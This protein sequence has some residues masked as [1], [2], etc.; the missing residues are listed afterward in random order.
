MRRGC[1]AEIRAPLPPTAFCENTPAHVSFLS[2]LLLPSTSRFPLPSSPQHAP[3]LRQVGFGPCAASPPLPSPAQHL[4]AEP[5]RHPS[6]PSPRATHLRR[7]PEPLPRRRPA[8]APPLRRPTA[9]PPA[10]EP[11]F[12]GKYFAAVPAP[13]LLLSG[14][15]PRRRRFIAA[16]RLLRAPFPSPALSLLCSQADTAYRRRAAKP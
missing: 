7:A 10:V 4:C 8:P 12:V 3:P 6:A 15:A 14:G 16:R 9:L 11:L 2:F 5:L 1:A 13:S